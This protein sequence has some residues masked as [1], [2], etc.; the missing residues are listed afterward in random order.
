[1]GLG[2]GL[3]LGLATLRAIECASRSEVC[4]S[5]CRERSFCSL[6]ARPSLLAPEGAQPGAAAAAGTAAQLGDAQPSRLPSGGGAPG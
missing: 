5:L 4:I 2:L 3:G 1:M 6:R